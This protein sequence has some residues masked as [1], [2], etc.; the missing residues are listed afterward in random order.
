[1]TETLRRGYP[2]M[3]VSLPSPFYDRLRKM[4]A[5]SHILV[6]FGESQHTE[7]IFASGCVFTVMRVSHKGW[8]CSAG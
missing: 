1:M 2:G 6:T 8:K 5:Q 7:Y 3:K 4:R